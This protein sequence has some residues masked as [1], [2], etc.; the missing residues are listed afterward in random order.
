MNADQ[1]R[2]FIK[3]VL[4]SLGY[5]WRRFDRKNTRRK[6]RRRMESLGIHEPG[7][8]VSLLADKP[9][10][11]A[12]FESLLPVTI[13][14]FFRNVWLW[15]S[16]ADLLS[17][18]GNTLVSDKGTL[19]I[20]SAG[21][22]SGEEAFTTAMLADDLTENGS[23]HRPWTVLG[24]DID[25]PSLER[26]CN[27]TYG[28]GSVREVPERI[29]RRWFTEK[30]GVWNLNG[31]LRKIVKIRR[32][33]FVKEDSPGLFHVVLLR[34]SVLTYNTEDIQREV[35]RKIRGCLMPTGF[36]IIGRTEKIPEGMGFREV[37]QCIYRKV[38][39]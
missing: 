23:L 39:G 30:G 37:S 4:P 20:W 9:E 32:H 16:L 5:Q 10:E 7:D 3:E 28:W 33:D 22:G 35:L 2:A 27:L 15:E 17:H 34:N 36:L 6:L 11:R 29:L 8:Y 12:V 14:R 25:A 19:D 26:V 13:T 1:Y 21:C 31:Q 38:E 18:R 24:T